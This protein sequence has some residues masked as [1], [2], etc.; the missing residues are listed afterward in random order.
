MVEMAVEA[1]YSRY[2]KT[3]LK[4]Y[5]GFCIVFAV[6]FAYDGYLSKYDWSLRR[7]FYEK[8]VKE[9]KADDNMVFNRK[10]PIFLF[11]AAFLLAFRLWT[12]RNRK[13]LAEENELVISDREKIT[14]DSIEKINKTAFDK[15]GVFVIT[16]RD[17]DGSETDLKL[18]DKKYDNLGLL[19]DEVVAKI[20]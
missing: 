11:A 5:T 20:S 6:I 2:R 1:P 15:K 14:Y 9:G 7:S 4:I 16:Y 10:A 12:V 19:L 13:L 3:N 18:S 17:K 8:H